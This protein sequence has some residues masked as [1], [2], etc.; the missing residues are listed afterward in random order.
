MSTIA[1]LGAFMQRESKAARE[2]S[3]P[4]VTQVLRM[5]SWCPMTAKNQS[6]RSPAPGIILG[7]LT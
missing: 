2:L 6:D 4:D 1:E 3:T 7:P 5:E